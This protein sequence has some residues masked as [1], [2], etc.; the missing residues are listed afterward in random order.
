M[1]RAAVFAFGLMVWA[2]ATQARADERSCPTE[3][4]LAHFDERLAPQPC[5]LIT[6]AEIHWAG[7]TAHL[8]AM[9][10]ADMAITDSDVF[11][12]RIHEIAAAVGAAMERMGG[13]LSL[14]ENVTI[15]FT[16]YASP[17]GEGPDEGFDKGAYIAGASSVFANECPI[18]YYKGTRPSVGDD[19]VFIAAH[20]I[21]HCIQ[22]R[23][24][25]SMPEEQWLTEGSAEY[26]GFLA[27][28]GYRGDNE[29]ITRFDAQI[30]GVALNNLDYS[31]VVFYLWL[32]HAYGP[33]R[34]R[35]FIG[36]ARSIDGAISPDAW[37]E[38]AQA[39]F[40]RSIQM[41][42]GG[43][44]ASTPQIGAT[45][46]ISGDDRLHIP[47]MVPYT[48]NNAIFAFERD[49]SYDLTYGPIPDDVR[50]R[51]RKVESGAWEAPLTAVSTCDG[52]QRYRVIWASTRSTNMGDI[53][54][55]V[56]PGGAAICTCP[57]GVWQETNESLRRMMEQSALGSSSTQFISGTRVLRLNPDHTGSF[58]Y[59]DVVTETRSAADFWLRQTKTG[60][61]HFTW[62]VVDGMVLTVLS[63]GDNLLTL[64]NEQHTP[65]GVIVEDR[66]AG[67]QSIGHNFSCDGN[68]LHLTQRALPAGSM[69]RLPG[70]NVNM[71]FVRVGA[72][73]APER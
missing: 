24:W 19:F 67:A 13:E 35:E 34:V 25:R 54:V 44:L 40:D 58:T 66:R 21:F 38:F 23:T 31:A 72:A 73:P 14:D 43:A 51:W 68:V 45:R 2:A 7:H 55:D 4:Y 69:A 29:F 3:G 62:R 30:P 46:T 61:A 59:N 15:L 17:R 22:Y 52:S 33:P 49:R 6:T 60:G 37:I 64:H 50:M 56:Q 12:G 42:D 16:N 39:Y 1:I 36:S 41:P 47:A 65:R 70:I 32:S 10:P 27:R 48:L 9:R 63:A 8:R 11:I 57:A 28:P 18:S 5:V 20:E 71:D 53:D 26:F